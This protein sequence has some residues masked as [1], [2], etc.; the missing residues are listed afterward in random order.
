MSRQQ[1]FND[2]IG[3]R[4]FRNKTSCPCKTCTKVYE[5]G[6]IVDDDMHSGYLC[7]TEAEYNIEG[8]PLRYFDT[9][10]EVIEFEKNS[11][12]VIVE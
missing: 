2:R 12:T 7:M 3:K 6:L 5:E 9:K 11:G 4:V 8:T 1:W 10:E